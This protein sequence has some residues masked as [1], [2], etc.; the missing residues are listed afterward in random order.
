MTAASQPTEDLP[1]ALTSTPFLL[2]YTPEPTPEPPVLSRLQI[3]NRTNVNQLKLVWRYEPPDNRPE[4][5]GGAFAFS[6][7][8]KTVALSVGDHVERVD[9]EQGKTM[10]TYSLDHRLPHW[11]TEKVYSLAFSPGGKRLAGLTEA[12]VVLWDVSSEKPLWVT[13]MEEGSNEAFTKMVF[14][15]GGD[16]IVTTSIAYGSDIRV[17]STETGE[18]VRALHRPNQLDAIFN[19]DGTQLFTVDRLEGFIWAWDT[20]TWEAVNFSE[21]TGAY[22][23]LTLSPNGKMVAVNS[24]WN[25]DGEDTTTLYLLDGWKCLG[26]LLTRFDGFILGGT[27]V[28]STLGPTRIEPSFNRDGGILALAIATNNLG[29]RPDH[30]ELWD[31][32]SLKLIASLDE[33]FPTPITWGAI[34]PDGR[35]L[36]ARSDNGT[37]IFW[38]VPAQ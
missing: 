3:I 28:Y 17:W 10:Q 13:K 37:I 34:S 25:G 35:L 9:L 27:P 11:A 21:T 7:D 5:W 38:G 31:T 1:P 26:S 12:G 29:S 30:M 16:V 8:G 20:V 22:A 32:A 6:P 2:P 36:A 33:T 4:T 18:Q 14:S 23:T 24:G 19:L 15:P